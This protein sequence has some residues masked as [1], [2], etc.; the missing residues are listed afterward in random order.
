MCVCSC[1]C[2]LNIVLLVCTSSSSLPIEQQY[3]QKIIESSVL[4][5]LF[6]GELNLSIKFICTERQFQSTP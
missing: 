6:V 1:V 5:K 2:I 3:D 4:A